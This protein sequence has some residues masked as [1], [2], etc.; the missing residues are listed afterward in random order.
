[1]KPVMRHNNIEVRPKWDRKMR[2]KSKRKNAQMDQRELGNKNWKDKNA[3][4]W[5][6][7]T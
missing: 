7:S 4:K 5:L 2:N 1:M 6:D 3:G